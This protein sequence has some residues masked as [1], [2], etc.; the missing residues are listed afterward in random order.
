[1]SISRVR[2]Q[3]LD[4]PHMSANDSCTNSKRQDQQLINININLGSCHYYINLV[5]VQI[6]CMLDCAKAER[7]Q[8][9]SIRYQQ[10]PFLSLAAYSAKM[11]LL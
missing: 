2:T 8:A 5:N 4:T 11:L 6:V 7:E 1:M 3:V 9:I 10:Q